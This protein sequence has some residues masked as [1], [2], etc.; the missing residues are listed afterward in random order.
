[1]KT[2]ISLFLCLL[3][4]CNASALQIARVSFNTWQY[5]VDDNMITV[6][7]LFIPGFG[8]NIAYLH[9]EFEL[10][11]ILNQPDF[12]SLIIKAY[13]FS[14][15]PDHLQDKVESAFSVP[16]SSP[17]LLFDDTLNSAENIINPTS[18]DLLLDA[19]I[20]NVW[21]FDSSGKYIASLKNN[22]GKI[23][24]H[25]LADGIYILGYIRQQRYKTTRIIL[26]KQ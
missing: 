18:G 14:Y 7:G 15:Q 21:I 1:M 26:K 12:Y 3:V 19:K 24:L 16:F 2:T 4:F 11:L 10:P 9:N 23:S 25:Q 5:S 8:S 20:S 17:L 13:Y 6:E 22:Q